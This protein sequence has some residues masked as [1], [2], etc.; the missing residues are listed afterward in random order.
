VE[1]VCPG[2]FFVGGGLGFYG[3]AFVDRFIDGIDECL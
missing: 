3:L 2:V 1:I